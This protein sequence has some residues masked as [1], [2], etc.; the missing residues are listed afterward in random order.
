MSLFNWICPASKVAFH[1]SPSTLTFSRQKSE[2]HKGS[3]TISLSDICKASIP[4]CSLSPIL[5]NGHL[6]TVWTAL[7]YASTPIWYKR[8]IFVSDDPIQNGQFCVDFV[9]NSL[10]NTVWN[11]GHNLS[12]D[13]S[14]LTREE[15]GAFESL[16]SKPMI[17][18]LH[19]LAG[20]SHEEYVR[21]V[22]VPLTID[23]WEACV[24][25]SRGCGNSAITSPYLFNA[26]STCDLRQFVRWLREKFPNR[27]LFGLGFSLGAN[28]LVNVSCHLP[29]APQV[30][31]FRP[32]YSPVVVPWRRGLLLLLKGGCSYFQSMGPRS[33][34]TSTQEI[35]DW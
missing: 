33:M 5:F 11:D 14:S 30:P 16:D 31:N 13:P 20:G 6:H 35:L 32:I 34:P 7:S 1:H 3:A 25:N 8:K 24:V 28:L 17:V 26:R 27:Q 4:P 10:V 18:C 9:V 15:L 22:L 21:Q 23:G 2:S 12:N 29:H 19:G